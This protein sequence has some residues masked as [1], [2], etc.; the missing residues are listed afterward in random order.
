MSDNNQAAFMS[1]VR[2]ALG[3]P[4]DV[5]RQVPPFLFH[6]HPSAKS[7][8]LLE[9]FKNRGP[10][11][12]QVV[13]DALINAA[14]PI[15]LE[16]SLLASPEDV[17]VA[18]AG[19]IVS[20][21]VEWGGPRKVCMWDHPLI[22]GLDLRSKLAERNIPVVSTRDFFSE[23]SGQMTTVQR[24]QFRQGVVDSF[25]GIT[26]AD[27]C[28]ADTATLVLRTTPGQPRSVSLVPSIH[29]AVITVDQIVADFGELYAALRWQHSGGSMDLTTCMTF[30][31]GPSKTADIEATL[32]HGAHGPKAV[33][34]YIITHG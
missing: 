3:H 13:L 8:R 33:W 25:V 6:A 2:K 26:S 32:V 1:T 12:R 24:Q 17:A 20:A 23:S 7:Q 10:D 31:S 15:N 11:Q 14:K 22:E 27:F 4:G 34:L 30:I 9:K 18:V 19:R 5:P 16:V 28:V 29:I 21:P